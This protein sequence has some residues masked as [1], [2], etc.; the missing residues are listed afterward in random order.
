MESNDGWLRREFEERAVIILTELKTNAVHAL[1]NVFSGDA[2]THPSHAVTNTHVASLFDSGA[3]G[4]G[5]HLNI[6]DGPRKQPK[7]VAQPNRV[8]Q[9][10]KQGDVFVVTRQCKPICKAYQDGTYTAGLNANSLCK[11]DSKSVHQC[12][13]CLRVGHG[14]HRCF[15][16][17]SDKPKG[18]KCGAKKKQGP[19]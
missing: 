16:N 7:H 12:A 8:D 2:P 9:S 14:L 5:G 3:S 6:K 11:S 18:G 15:A 4:S 19:P 13:H 10:V 1:G 17:K